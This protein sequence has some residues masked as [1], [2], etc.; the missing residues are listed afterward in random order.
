MFLLARTV[1]FG[2]VPLASVSAGQLSRQQQK[3]SES[4]RCPICASSLSV[5]GDWNVVF[6]HIDACKK[7]KADAIVESRGAGWDPGLL[8]FFH[9]S[10]K[11]LSEESGRGPRGSGTSSS[12]SASAT[13]SA[14]E[15][16]VDADDFAEIVPG[17]YISAVGPGKCVP[18]LKSRCIKCVVNC[19]DKKESRPLG[20]EAV[21]EASLSKYLCLDMDDAY[22]EGYSTRIL[23]GAA[24][25]NEINLAGSGSQPVLVHCAA[26]VSRSGTVLIT[27]L[28][29]YRGMTLA[30]ALKTAR[31]G[32]K[33]IYPAL[34]FIKWLRSLD[35]ELYGTHSVPEDLLDLHGESIGRGGAV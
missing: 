13:P 35:V 24:A 23:N 4:F 6:T 10:S 8:N 9:P 30:T 34:S 17:V 21:E 3:M 16:L 33:K 2:R 18:W 12:S 15:S 14:A 1:F 7:S 27:F 31:A 28:M 20:A 19:I 22:H 5:E 32:R 26:G 29:K 25:L 11:M